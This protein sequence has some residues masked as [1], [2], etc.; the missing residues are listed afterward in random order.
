MGL[1][2]RPQR[3]SALLGGVAAAGYSARM[4]DD[5]VADLLGRVLA[6]QLPSEE[7][8]MAWWRWA[9]GEPTHALPE[10]QQLQIRAHDHALLVGAC[11]YHVR[12]D[13]RVEV[14]DYRDPRSMRSQFYDPARPGQPY[15]SP[16]RE[17]CTLPAA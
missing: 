5:L 11:E 4:A 9:D 10:D 3:V 7:P 17:D 2:T 13:G 15:M 12:D 1:G 6:A 14:R 8:L 16:S